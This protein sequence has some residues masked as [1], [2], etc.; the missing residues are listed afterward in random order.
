MTLLQHLG[1]PYEEESSQAAR[2]HEA[3]TVNPP[4]PAIKC[5]LPLVATLAI[6]VFPIS[7]ATACHV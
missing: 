2:A 5:K 7:A 4:A 6:A 3:S 1:D